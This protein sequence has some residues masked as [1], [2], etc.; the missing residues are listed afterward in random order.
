LDILFKNKAAYLLMNSF[1]SI[2]LYKYANKT[3]SI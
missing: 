1:N 3:I 2:I